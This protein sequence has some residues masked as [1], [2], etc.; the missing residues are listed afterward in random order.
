MLTGGIKANI[1]AYIQSCLH[2]GI[3]DTQKNNIHNMLTIS[4][5]QMLVKVI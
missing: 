5:W 3:R 2:E 1:V 4:Y